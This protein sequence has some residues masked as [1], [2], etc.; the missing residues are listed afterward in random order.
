M[1]VQRVRQ[2]AHV[3]DYCLCLFMSY[4]KDSYFIFL[5]LTC[6]FHFHSNFHFYFAGIHI[7]ILYIIFLFSYLVLVCHMYCPYSFFRIYCVICTTLLRRFMYFCL[8]LYS[9]QRSE[10]QK[11]IAPHSSGSFRTTSSLQMAAKARSSRSP[12]IPVG[13]AE[14][15]Q[16]SPT[17]Y[18]RLIFIIYVDFSRIKAVL[19]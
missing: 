3:P 2:Y 12:F 15:P 5:L 10:V 16:E 19:T 18:R 17:P 14:E 6:Y 8:F 7:I 4:F 11:F 13:V 9:P 1:K